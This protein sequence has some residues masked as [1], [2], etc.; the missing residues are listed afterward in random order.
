MDNIH[1]EIQGTFMGLGDNTLNHL[2]RGTGLAIDEFPVISKNNDKPLVEN[3]VI[4]LGFFSAL[5]GYGVTGMQHTYIITAEG[6][7]SINGDADDVVVA[8]KYL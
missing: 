3:M 4:N 8:G 6:C 7:I 5:E 2:G 1:P